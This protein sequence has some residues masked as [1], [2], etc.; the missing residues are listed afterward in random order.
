MKVKDLVFMILD[1]CKLTSSDDAYITSEHVIFLIKKYMDD[2]RYR[3]ADGKNNL[4]IVKNLDE[5]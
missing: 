4:T 3:F 1:S 2:V 5:K